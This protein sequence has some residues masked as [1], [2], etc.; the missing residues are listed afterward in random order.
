MINRVDKTREVLKDGKLP[1][2]ENRS[3]RCL[4]ASA[5]PYDG[6]CRLRK[7]CSFYRAVLFVF[8]FN[9]L[10]AFN[11]GGIQMNKEKIMEAVTMLIEA[12]GEDPQREGLVDTPDRIA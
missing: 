5:V 3:L 11:I 10:I 1:L 9:N 6:D 12:I 7:H 8:I 2:N 4:I